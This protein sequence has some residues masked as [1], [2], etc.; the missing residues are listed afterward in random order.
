MEK[1][2]RIKRGWYR[3][4]KTDTVIIFIH[5]L[6]SNCD[7]CW[8]NDN[9][10][11]WPELVSNDP[12]LDGAS[13]YLSEYYTSATSGD[14]DFNQ[15]ANE[16][17]TDITSIGKDLQ[18]P[19]IKNKKIIF[20]GHSAGGIISRLVVEKNRL[21]FKEKNLGFF[22]VASPSIGSNYNLLA[23][24]CISLCDHAL[25]K[26]LKWKSSI[27]QD[28]DD[29][30]RD[31]IDRKELNV[32]GREIFENKIK[33]SGIVAFFNRKVVEKESARRYF[34][35]G[36]MI[37]NS[38]HS[39][40]CKPNDMDHHSH[41]ELCKF[42]TDNFQLRVTNSVIPT[43]SY[44]N[45]SKANPLF[46]RYEKSHDQYYII[47]SIDTLLENAFDK[48]SI[49]VCGCSGVG[50][51]VS[52]Q[53]ALI[54]K[55]LRFRYVSLARSVNESIEQMY[56]DLLNELN[57]YKETPTISKSHTLKLISEKIEKLSSDGYSALFI[58]E[59]PIKT[60][61][62]FIE[63]SE[64]LFTIIPT[65]DSSKSICHIILSSI[66]EPPLMEGTEFEKN[67]TRLKILKVNKW[68][69][70]EIQQLCDVIEQGLG[71][72]LLNNK[73]EYYSFNGSPRSVKKFYSEHLFNKR[74]S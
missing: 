65:I 69:T 35:S 38:D 14:F 22:L 54:L 66:F 32:C 12:R 47:K 17:F 5:G 58:E 43:S 48:Y 29:R 25:A 49:W 45:N 23:S 44:V 16:V 39:S 33:K 41:K 72:S 67:T 13:I 28:L 37:P 34:G 19:P 60:E 63:F 27:L 56:T 10:A 3:N 31:I 9:G 61:E 50:K 52:I 42:I 51:T 4:L 68:S 30:F 7:K 57:D 62:E 2:I 24:I 8:R 11:F 53:R 59:I 20:V 70:E 73:E 74:A 55:G 46:D 36:V 1:S 6:M 64:S 18:A 21:Y 15:C 40:I 71:I 26:E